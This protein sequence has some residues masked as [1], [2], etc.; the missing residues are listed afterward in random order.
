MIK[1]L[2]TAISELVPQGLLRQSLAF[3]NEDQTIDIFIKKERPGENTVS[4]TNHDHVLGPGDAFAINKDSDG[5]EAVQ[6]RWTAIA[7]SGTPIIS[8][9][10]SET[11]KR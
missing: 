3:K 8:I 5:I 2:S 9:F 4:S 1:T 6:D 11:V 10:E 7:A